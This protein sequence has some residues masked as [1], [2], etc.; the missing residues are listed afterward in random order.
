MHEQIGLLRENALGDFRLMVQAISKDPAML[1]Y[2]DS[3]TNRKRHPNENYA[4]EV[5]ELF[6]LGEGNYNERDV[7]ELAKCFTGWEIRRGK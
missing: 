4:R 2:L 3:V 6:C 5:M 1:I 7:V